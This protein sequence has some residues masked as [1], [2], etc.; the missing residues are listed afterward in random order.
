MAVESY[1]HVT[2]RGDNITPSK[3]I[4]R[5]YK[6]PS[7]TILW[8]FLE[9]N[10]E[11]SEALGEGPFLPIGMTVRIPIDPSILRGQPPALRQ[12]RLYGEA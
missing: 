9:A 11:V 4:W 7:R 12:V 5:R 8:Q 1:E 6:R 10:P 3:L 2:I